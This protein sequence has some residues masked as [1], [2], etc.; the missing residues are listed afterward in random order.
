MSKRAAKQPN[1]PRDAGTSHRG[2]QLRHTITVI[3]I[4]T[5]EACT[6][7]ELGERLGVS[8]RTVYRVFD[9]LE[10]FGISLRSYR[11][12]QNVSYRIS[13]VQARKALGL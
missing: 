5:G 12:A 7:V 6:V 8:R 3:K 4:L 9:V 1:V 11:E 2:N 13:K 10:D